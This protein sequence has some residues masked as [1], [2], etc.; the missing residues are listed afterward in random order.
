MLP[1]KYCINTC[2]VITSIVYGPADDER[3]PPLKKNFGDV[4][5]FI[6]SQNE[7]FLF[8]GPKEHLRRRPKRD[9]GPR[10]IVRYIYTLS[11]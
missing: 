10:S 4:T 3:N 1:I 5:S 6:E 7:P 2:A 9:G 8:V 11:M